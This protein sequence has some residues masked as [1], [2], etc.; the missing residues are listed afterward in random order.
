MLK[1]TFSDLTYSDYM[2]NQRQAPLTLKDEKI[3]GEA[4]EKGMS[5]KESD[6]K[7]EIGLLETES[8][9]LEASKF[10][11]TDVMKDKV[12]PLFDPVTLNETLSDKVC[13]LVENSFVESVN[14]PAQMDGPMNVKY[15]SELKNK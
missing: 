8:V 10:K 2:K 3:E 7:C 6:V 4:S 15:K 9:N 5:E 11:K 12:L 13:C 14:L 1:R